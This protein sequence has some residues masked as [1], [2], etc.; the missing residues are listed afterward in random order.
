[1]KAWRTDEFL[2][3]LIKQILGDTQLKSIKSVILTQQR[4][5]EVIEGFYLCTLRTFCEILKGD[6]YYQ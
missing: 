6:Q 4:R 1:M 5:C 2:N 3:F